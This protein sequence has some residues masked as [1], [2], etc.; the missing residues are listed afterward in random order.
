LKPGDSRASS[1][2]LP[3]TEHFIILL[4]ALSDF[5]GALTLRKSLILIA[6]AALIIITAISLIIIN[7]DREVS[8]LNRDNG[9]SAV[10]A[11]DDFKGDLKRYPLQT[12][13]PLVDRLQIIIDLPETMKFNDKAPF[14]LKAVSD[15]K[16]TVE[17]GDFD[18]KKA[19][20]R[21]RVP[22]DLSTGSATLEIT[23]SFSYCNKVNESL[24]FFQNLRL[25][26][27]L[28]IAHGGENTLEIEYEVIE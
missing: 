21:L 9:L 14:T 11:V 15:N 7:R 4:Q 2:L 19:R 18:Y 22:I 27:P 16:A 23:L 13:S 28:E 6:V 1:L 12:V 26:V 25:H 3:T 24:C 10:E 8:K 5:I 20:P 17:I